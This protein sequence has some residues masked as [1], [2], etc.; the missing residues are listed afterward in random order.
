[1]TIDRTEVLKPCK[2]ELTCFRGLV[3]QAQGILTLQTQ[4]TDFPICEA[5][6]QESRSRQTRASI[7]GT[8]S[9]P[10]TAIH[11]QLM[12]REKNHVDEL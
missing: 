1:M 5:V 4:I 7:E 9:C 10:V 12:D 3:T 6:V 8:Y 2:N 11:F